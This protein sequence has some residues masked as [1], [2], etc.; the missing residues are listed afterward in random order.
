LFVFVL[1]LL[2]LRPIELR[3][4]SDDTAN[5]A[6]IMSMGRLGWLEMRVT[7]WQ[8]RV[9]SDFVFSVLLFHLPLW[10]LLNAAVLAALLWVVTRTAAYGDEVSARGR[11]F[12]TLGTSVCLGLFLIHPNVITSGSV[13]F[14]G[15]FYYLWPT[16]AM[17]LGLA[18]F[19]LGLYGNRLPYPRVLAPLCFIFSLCACQ[20][21]QAAA[22]QLGISAL[23]LLW[24]AVKKAPI[25]GALIVQF[26]MIVV[27]SAVFFYFDFTSTRVTAQPELALFPQFAQFGL[28]DKLMLGVNVYTT[29]LLHVSNI[30]FTVFLGFVGWLAFR[31]KGQGLSSEHRRFSVFK[32]LVFLPALWALINTIPMPWGYTKS[33]SDALGGKPGALGFGDLS[34]L[35]YL[36]VTTPMTNSPSLGGVVL[37]IAALLC[38]LSPLYLLYRAFPDRV[39][40][41]LAI[42][43]YLASF[44]SGILIGFSP[45]VWASESRPNYISN[46][47]LLLLLAML[48]RSAMRPSTVALLPFD[49][50]RGAIVALVV[51]AVFAVFVI[52]LYFTTFATNSYWWY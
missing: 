46:F 49:R 43:F 25:P 39:D 12:L 52:L 7:T 13:W 17:L 45:S 35:S 27:A 37:S 6:A 19:L 38:V 18:P 34:W 20:T 11:S 14:T 9:I 31:R 8:P 3:G 41:Y 2:I 4:G 36:Y 24:L 44:F 28:L 33:T 50:S 48:L 15:S 16:A 42:V 22:V 47:I 21:E 5:T 51:L 23:V 29:H 26:A 40:R 10:K 32:A 1:F 30:V